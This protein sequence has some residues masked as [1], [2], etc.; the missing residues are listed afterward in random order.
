MLRRL[1]LPATVPCLVV[2]ALSMSCGGSGDAD[3][4]ATPPASTPTA[5]PTATPAATP[6]GATPA[7]TPAGGTAA[8]AATARAEE[9][10]T[11][12]APGV[13]I[14]VG[15]EWAFGTGLP[16]VPAGEVTF[17]MVNEGAVVHDLWVI[18]T[19]TPYDGLPV[20]GGVAV[21]GGNVEV[22]EKVL[23]TPAGTTVSLTAALEPGSYALIC[24][25]PAHYELGMRAPFT[26]E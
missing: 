17:E 10:Q 16:S 22:I 26:A 2:A 3:P 18:R 19:D 21:T 13:V 24:N 14:V 4:P 25:V 1:G 6:A 5:A 12:A 15:V 11:A 23:E 9:L 7:A 8:Q 20:Q